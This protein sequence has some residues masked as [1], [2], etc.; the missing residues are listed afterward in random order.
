MALLKEFDFEINHI[1]GKK[2]RVADALSRSVKMIHLE[3]VSTCETNVKDRVR[4]T[5][6][7]YAFFKTVTSY[8]KKE[9]AHRS[10]V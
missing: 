3:A 10:K 2:N 7:T 6:E 1:K 9:P 8:L 5:Q 4:N